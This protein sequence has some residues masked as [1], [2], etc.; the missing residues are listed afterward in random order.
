[1]STVP[2]VPTRFGPKGVT[3]TQKPQLLNMMGQLSPLQ[4]NTYFQD[5][6]GGSDLMQT[7]PVDWTV[8]RISAPQVAFQW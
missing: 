8:T 7:T 6:N 3:N 4:F 2:G 1:M 5:F